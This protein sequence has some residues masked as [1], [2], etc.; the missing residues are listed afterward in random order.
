MISN[1]DQLVAPI[2]RARN[3]IQIGKSI[4]IVGW[5]DLNHTDFTRSLPKDKVVFFGSSPRAMGSTIGFVLFSRYI[6]HKVSER[7]KEQKDVHPIVLEP[8][9]IKKILV[10]CQNLFVRDVH[11]SDKGSAPQT[12]SNNCAE[13]AGS[14]C[15]LPDTLLTALPCTPAIPSPCRTKKPNPKV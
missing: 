1:H 8:R 14:E 9:Q 7:I 10:S 15:L 4:A 3:A 5:T 12:Q 6:K 13:V 11:C 2:E